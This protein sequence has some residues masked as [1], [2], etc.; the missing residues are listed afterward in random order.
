M[1]ATVTEAKMLE[2][3]VG[4]A[5]LEIV[6]RTQAAGEWVTGV[7]LLYPGSEHQLVANFGPDA[8]AGRRGGESLFDRPPNLTPSRHS[9]ARSGARNPEPRMVQ[10]TA[11]RVPLYFYHLSVW[12]PGSAFA[13]PE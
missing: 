5:C 3:A 4:E 9:G 10:D 12:I 1:N 6:R 2:L 13:A 7:R 11:E 8:G